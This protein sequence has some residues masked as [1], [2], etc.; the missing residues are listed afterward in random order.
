MI[1]ASFG[2]LRSEK[3]RE[4]DSA[5]DVGLVFVETKDN[6][7]LSI[8]AEAEVVRDR[9]KA[10]AILEAT[11]NLWWEGPNDPNV[12]LLRVDPLTAELW[13]GPSNKIITA[14]EIAKSQITGG[15]PNLGEN[16][17]VTVEMRT[18]K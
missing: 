1:R 7:Y 13:D 12:C 17:K 4:I 11:D 6:A 2:Y 14:I 18:S 16:R 8:T 15:E 9:A 5:H 10:A 3:D